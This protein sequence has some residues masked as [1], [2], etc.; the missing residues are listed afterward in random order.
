MPNPFFKLVFL[1]T[2]VSGYWLPETVGNGKF[3][4]C[5]VP[6]SNGDDSPA[7]ISTVKSCGDNSR[8][9]F[10]SGKE[11]NLLT[12][13]KFSG[14]TNVEFSIQGNFTLSDDPSA[15]S[16]VV[17]NST[18]YPG[19]WITVSN[20]K[21]V[22]F[23]ATDTQDGGW[24]NGHGDKWWPNASDSSDKGRPHL[25]SFGVTGLRLRGLKVLNPVAWCFSMGGQDVYMT[26][27]L[28]D[29]RSM[30][31]FP[32]N[33]DGIDVSAS[34]V[35]IDGWTSYNGDDIINVSP[36]AVNVTMRNIVAYGTHGISVSC[37]AGNGSGYLF[38]NAEI[39]DSLL[40]ARFKGSV[41]TT[42]Q[43]SDVTWRNMT[44]TNTSYPIH[45]IEDYVDQ[46]KGAAGK[47]AS[48]AAFAKNFRWESIH[49]H[50][51]PSLKD[52][53]CVS[54]PC[55]SKTLGESTKKGLYMICKDADHCQDFHFSDITLASADGG[56]GEMVC[57]GL[58]GA[59]NLGI[60][61]TNSTLPATK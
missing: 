16:A 37:S 53:S 23:T 4:T 22:T 17:Q 44:I 2:A 27:T 52:G 5:I 28:L 60:P 40:G 10:S 7:I 50:T 39:H 38:E 15:V 18:I 31:G 47:D 30:N 45:F 42:C 54:T 26:D 57:V 59:T 6:K 55:W 34:D 58:E 8:I 24:I 61:C 46:E 33:T 43:I 36:P 19:H 9:V 49:A 35:V 14:L 21:G 20:S 51:G 32:F 13:L 41:G 29:A 1:A 48:L 3:K 56:A 11:Y 12:P 25:F